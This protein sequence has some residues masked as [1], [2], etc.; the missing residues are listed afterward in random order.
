MPGGGKR[1]SG[2]ARAHHARMPQ[3]FVDALAIQPAGALSSAP[4]CSPRAA[5][6]ARRA[7]RTAN[8]DRAPCRSAVAPLAAALDVFR[9]QIGI[10]IRTVAAIRPVAA[11]RPALAHRVGALRPLGR[12]GRGGRPVRSPR[13]AAVAALL[14][15]AADGAAA[16]LAARSGVGRSLRA[17]A[18]ASAGDRRPRLAP[19][20]GPVARPQPAARAARRRRP[21]SRGGRCG[22]RCRRWP[23]GRPGRQTSISSGSAGAAASAAPDASASAGDRLRRAADFGCSDVVRSGFA[24]AVAAPASSGRHRLRRRHATGSGSSDGAASAG[25]LSAG[26]AS[27][28]IAGASVGCHGFG[29]AASA[30]AATAASTSAGASAGASVLAPARRPR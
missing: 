12:S 8:S 19:R 10:A 3:P 4:C 20:P 17:A 27:A 7:W 21:A 14:P 11:V 18:T 6:S 5:P 29:R 22:R 13:S 25:R 15:L 24:E 9:A 16:R 28:S 30:L 2:L 26:A 23:S 1:G